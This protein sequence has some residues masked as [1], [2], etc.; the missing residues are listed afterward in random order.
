MTTSWTNPTQ[1]FQYS[2]PGAES[3]HKQW[4]FSD[5]NTVVGIGNKPIGIDGVLEHIA[6]SP[7]YDITNKTYYF[8]A[9]GYQFTNV[10]DIISGVE[11]R[12]TTDRVGRV[13]DDTIQLCLNEEL[14]GENMASISVDPVKIY[15]GETDLWGAEISLL[16]VM[17]MSFGVV[18]RLRSHPHW[19]HRDSAFIKALEVRIH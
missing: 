15:G 3:I 8:R 10:P 9:T 19:P 5:S 11:L 16:D 2:E 12:L 13:S 4:K 18:I 6:R 17:D 1:I 7:K 14:V